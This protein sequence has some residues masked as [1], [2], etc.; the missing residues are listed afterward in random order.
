MRVAL[1]YVYPNLLPATYKIM[2][3]R[4]VE[5]YMKHPP[6]LED[7]DIHVVVNGGPA[8]K[9]EVEFL[10]SPIKCHFMSHDNAG[11]DLGGYL[12][13]AHEVPCDLMVCLGA[14]VHFHRAG[15][16]DRLVSAYEDNGPGLYGPF[17][18]REPAVHIRTTAFMCAPELLRAY[19]F[20]ITNDSRY[21]FEYGGNSFTRYVQS[22]GLPCR[23]V[24]WSECLEEPHWEQQPESEC[25]FWDQHCEKI[26]YG[27]SK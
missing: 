23:M 14:P 13:A 21:A 27:K 3:R 12:K 22:V 20:E 6:G 15:W 11:K 2:A 9:S 5:T 18:A 16:L 26:G 10:F 24:T 4:F 8:R 25:L 19:P 1:V 17:A 7:H